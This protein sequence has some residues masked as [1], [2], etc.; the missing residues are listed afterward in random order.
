MRISVVAHDRIC[1]ACAFSAV[2]A[3][4]VATKA[5]GF[6]ATPTVA[7]GYSSWY[8]NDQPWTARSAY[9]HSSSKIGGAPSAPGAKRAEINNGE[10]PLYAVISVA[11]QRISIPSLE[12]LLCRTDAV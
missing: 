2:F 11:D 1:C 4:S 8:D 10:R 9:G 7:L 12:Y 5:L 3:V 6:E